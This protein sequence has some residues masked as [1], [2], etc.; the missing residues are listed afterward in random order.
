MLITDGCTEIEYKGSTKVVIGKFDGIHLGHQKLIREITKINDGRPS[1]VFT[2]KSGSK[3][4]K[5]DIRIL[6]EEERRQ[7]FEELG[8]DILVEFDLNEENAKTEPE[9]FVRDILVKRLHA[10][11]IVA[12]SDV[13]FGRFGKGNLELLTKLSKEYGFEVK[14][15]DKVMYE[16]EPISSTRIREAL[17]NGNNKSAGEM[18]GRIRRDN[19]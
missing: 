13:S 17:K 6:T 9:D 18:L 3:V 7:I 16:N 12:G 1:V 5:N 4:L 2:F 14:T 15:I 8:T 11:L 10:G 19:V